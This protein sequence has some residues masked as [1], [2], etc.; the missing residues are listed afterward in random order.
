[1]AT[2]SGDHPRSPAEKFPFVI[3][4]LEDAAEA[5]TAV[6]VDTLT[7]TRA[8][9]ATVHRRHDRASAPPKLV[10]RSSL[11]GRSSSLH[12]LGLL[13]FPS[14]TQGNMSFLSAHLA[15]EA[16][17]W[18]EREAMA[19]CCGTGLRRG[20]L[21]SVFCRHRLGRDSGATAGWRAGF[22]AGAT[23][24]RRELGQPSD[25]SSPGD[26]RFPPPLVRRESPARSALANPSATGTSARDRSRTTPNDA[27]LLFLVNSLK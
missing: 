23:R 13:P 11:T 21:A 15:G 24:C 9:V 1:M 3:A 22:R 7:T 17:P 14:T 20:E 2:T 12:P 5:A 19:A 25:G 16:L 26:T 6:P 4:F 10:P 27:E 18:Q 8:T